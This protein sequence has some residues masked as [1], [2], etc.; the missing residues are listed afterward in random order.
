MN[1]KTE[2]KTIPLKEVSSGDVFFDWQSGYFFLKTSETYLGL[3]EEEP[4][5][6]GVVNLE[7]GTLERV[8]DYNVEVVKGEFV[9]Q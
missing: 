3:D 6:Y 8:V 9:C 4:V 5:E 7:C 2:R 1:V